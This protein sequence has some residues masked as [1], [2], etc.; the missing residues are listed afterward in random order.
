MIKDLELGTVIN[1]RF[2][3]NSVIGKGGIG[4]VYEAT[5]RILHRKVALKFL[6]SG[7]VLTHEQAEGAFR[8][9]AI[10]T[11]QFTHPNIVMVFD[12]GFY[13]D[14]PY[15]VMEYLDGMTLDQRL[16]KGILEIPEFYS[17]ANH[18]L[19]GLIAAHKQK[20]VHCDLKP[21]N[22]MLMQSVGS[23]E[24]QVK[25]LDFGISQLARGATLKETEKL[26]VLVGSI[27]FMSPELI[28]GE[29]VDARSDLYSLGVIFYRSLTG[30][31]PLNAPTTDELVEK[32]LNEQPPSPRPYR[33]DFPPALEP[34]IMKMLEKDPPNRYPN[35]K[36]V[37][38]ALRLAQAFS[39]S[40]ML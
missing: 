4:I 35:A 37:K 27:Y 39:D 34:I 36:R 8:R 20:L 5:D 19:D 21:E 14:Q 38:E 10:F 3:I 13:K 16:V 25:I 30:R 2:V 28:L 40:K 32:Q 22:I 18:I 31:F 17:I 23:K 6:F 9:E 15:V 24:W 33:A 7:D 11:A 12:R 29:E 26:D 1:D